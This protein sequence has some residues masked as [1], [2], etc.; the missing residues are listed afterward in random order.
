MR[1]ET[2]P[3]R[4]LRQKIL[5]PLVAHNESA[6]GPGRFAPLAVTVRGPDGEVVGGLWGYSH[7]EFLFVELLALGPAKGRGLGRHVMQL[8]EAEARRRGLLGIWLDTW[9]FQAP[10]FYPKF[11]FVECG[12][13]AGY[14]PGHDR[15]FFVKR[16]AAHHTAPLDR[17]S[18]P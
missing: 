18:A 1:L 6:G 2:E 13:I 9:T 12:R 4:S 10:D 8:A 7:Y 11:G 16:F 14:P 3:D 17:P 15:I 5:D